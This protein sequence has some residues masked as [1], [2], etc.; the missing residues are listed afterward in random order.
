MPAPR[1][2][3]SSIAPDDRE[4]MLPRPA[5]HTPPTG[6]GIS[7]IAGALAHHGTAPDV[8]L[9]GMLHKPGR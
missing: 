3:K 6:T 5:I 4:E 7:A 8:S 9:R 2:L 1:G